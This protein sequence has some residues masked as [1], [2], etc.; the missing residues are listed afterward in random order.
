MSDES[1]MRLAT[2]E[3]IERLGRLVIG[4]MVR[5]PAE[6]DKQQGSELVSG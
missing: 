2:D 1:R 3:G 4:P 6:Q 5:P